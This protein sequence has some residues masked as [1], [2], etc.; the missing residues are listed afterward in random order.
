MFLSKAPRL[1]SHTTIAE[2]PEITGEDLGRATA[3]YK[4]EWGEEA[5]EFGLSTLF[6]IIL[7]WEGLRH[8]PKAICT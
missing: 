2:T 8:L 3:G 7:C 4:C 5:K 6:F 1:L